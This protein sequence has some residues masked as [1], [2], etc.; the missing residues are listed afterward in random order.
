VTEQ[1]TQRTESSFEVVTDVL[2]EPWLA[3]TI[4]L[5]PDFEGDVVATL[6]SRRTASPSE[7]AT[8]HVHGFSDY[9]FHAEY[10]EWWIQRGHDMYALDLRK[11]GRSIR[12]H[13]SATYVA[14]LSEYYDELDAA[15]ERRPHPRGDLR[16]LHRRPDRLSLGGLAEAEGAR[17]DRAQLPLARHAGQALDALAGHDGP[18]QAGRRAPADARAAAGGAGLLHAQPAP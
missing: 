9:F 13:Q 10:G 4:P 6:V 1:S 11:Y 3:E 14:D 2:G 17:G 12:P 15:W 7:R 16:P 18:D 5:E 8:L